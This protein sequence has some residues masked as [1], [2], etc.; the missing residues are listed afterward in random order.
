MA[1]L[2]LVRKILSDFPGSFV[3]GGIRAETRHGSCAN[4]VKT[5]LR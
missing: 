5:T 4:T 3:L 2:K 1:W